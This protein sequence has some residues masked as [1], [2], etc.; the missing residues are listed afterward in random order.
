MRLRF[1]GHKI[2]I[3]QIFWED[4]LRLNHVPLKKKMFTGRNVKNE[5][6]TWKKSKQGN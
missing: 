2:Q 5:E 4:H 1:L 6:V 3:H